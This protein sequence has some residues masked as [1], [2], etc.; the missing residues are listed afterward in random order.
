[1]TGL[2][3]VDGFKFGFKCACGWASDPW[4]MMTISRTKNGN[5]VSFT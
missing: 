3:D 5:T 2:A 1:M 4:V